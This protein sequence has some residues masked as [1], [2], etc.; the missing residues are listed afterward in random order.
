MVPLPPGE[1]ILFD[2]QNGQAFTAP[3]GE[4]L[5]V[6]LQ[7]ADK[8]G[9]A[10][11]VTSGP[12]GVVLLGQVYDRGASLRRPTHPGQPAPQAMGQ[13]VMRFRV[14]GKPGQTVKLALAYTRANVKLGL[15]KVYRVR[16]KVAPSRF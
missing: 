16:I 1:L 3:V 4:L 5:V 11:R 8:G 13:Q 6:R 15:A 9:N 2:A 7:A 12:P 10:W 14:T